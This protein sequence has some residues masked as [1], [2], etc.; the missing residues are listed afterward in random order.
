[1]LLWFTDAA[2]YISWSLLLISVPLFVTTTICLFIHVLMDVCVS[3]PHLFSA[4][5]WLYLILLIHIMLFQPLSSSAPPPLCQKISKPIGT[6]K[7]F[8]RYLRKATSIYWT[9]CH[10]TCPQGPGSSEITYSYF[11][12]FC[13]IWLLLTWKIQY[14]EYYK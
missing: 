8:Y 13:N 5:F 1:M 9:K 10:S 7:D 12:I 14:V 6:R 2:A 3:F 4:Y 11:L